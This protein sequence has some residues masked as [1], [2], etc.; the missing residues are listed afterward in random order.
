MGTQHWFSSAM[1]LTRMSLHF[2]NVTMVRR[3]VSELGTLMCVCL[4][5]IRI[6]PGL[7]GDPLACN[8]LH[9][10]WSSGAHE[11]DWYLDIRI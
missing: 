3:M 6:S 2:V 10:H 11:R 1:I 9:G 4:L 5:V 8:D 7:S